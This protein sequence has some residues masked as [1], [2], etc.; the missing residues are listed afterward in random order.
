MG[1]QSQWFKAGGGHFIYVGKVDCSFKKP[2][3]L[4]GCWSSNIQLFS[5]QA[6]LG[7]VSKSTV[8]QLSKFR[9]YQFSS[10]NQWVFIQT[11]VTHT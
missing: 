6:G 1:A 2:T 7:C 4:W 10:V 3:F 5:S 8:S 9:L 11:M